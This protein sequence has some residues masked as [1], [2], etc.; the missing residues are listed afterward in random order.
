MSATPRPPAR[1]LAGHALPAD[2]ARLARRRGRAR[3]RGLSVSLDARQLRRFARRR[4][5]RLDAR[6]AA[7]AS[8]SATAWRCAAPT[9]CTC[10]TSPSRRRRA[11]AATRGACSTRWSDECRDVDAERLWLEVR[12]SQRRRAADLSAARLHQGRRAQGLLPGAG[13]HARGCGRHEPRSSG[14]PPEAPMRWTERQ[15][16]ML[17]E[18]GIRVWAPAATTAPA[19]ATP[20][21]R[22]RAVRAGG[23]VRGGA[24]GARR[25]AAAHARV[26]G[27]AAPVPIVARRRDRSR[28][29]ATRASARRSAADWLVVGEPLD[30]RSGRRRRA[31]TAARQHAARDRRRRAARGARDG[32]RP[33]SPAAEATRRRAPR[34]AAHRCGDRRGAAALHPR[35]RPRRRRGAARRR[36]AARRPARRRA[37]ARG[38]MP[39]VVTFALPYLLRHPADKAQ[40]WA[41]LCLRGRG[42]RLKRR[43]RRPRA[44]AS[45]RALS[46]SLIGRFQPASVAWRARATV[47]WPAGASL[48][49][50]EPPPIVA[51]SPTVDRRHQHAVAADVHVGADRRCGACWR[52]RSWR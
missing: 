41:D 15:R 44:V 5:H 26:A 1:S 9:R 8:C 42:D 25:R 46:A 36:R 27:R 32:A 31:G 29:A 6:T 47:S 49:I 21:S 40:A 19:S 39:V 33:S 3:D 37:R 45:A 4:L 18:M 2:D 10:S 22:E 14:R 12:E 16:A 35:L 17:R 13:R 38:G 34:A 23:G 30:R 43:R 7:T 28:A 11:G 24:G 50:V 51:P 20:S 52:R 48:A